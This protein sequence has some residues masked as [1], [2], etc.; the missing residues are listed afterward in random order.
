MVRHAIEA[1]NT[2]DTSKVQEFISAKYINRELQSAKDS[3]RSK[4]R[5]SEEFVDTIKNYNAA[6]PSTK[7]SNKITFLHLRRF[8]HRFSYLFYPPAISWPGVLGN[9]RGITSF[10]SALIKCYLSNQ[11]DKSLSIIYIQSWGLKNAYR[12]YM[13]WNCLDK[14]LYRLPKLYDLLSDPYNIPPT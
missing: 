10:H 12:D 9:L 5:G 6:S 14:L 7:Y 1:F 2:G 8:R 4:L 3:Y 13:D 11:S